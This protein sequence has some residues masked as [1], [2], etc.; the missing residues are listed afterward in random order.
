MRF[1]KIFLVESGLFGGGGKDLT[2]AFF[3]EAKAWKFVL[4]RYKKFNLERKNWQK[5]KGFRGVVFA[6]N[7]WL[8]ISE[9]VCK[10]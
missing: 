6:R 10:G 1:Q 7:R 9:I 8:L 2:R 4:R 3:D 5:H